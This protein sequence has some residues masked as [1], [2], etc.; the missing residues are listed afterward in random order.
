MHITCVYIMHI[1]ILTGTA[2]PTD[3]II[4]EL[5]VARNP[6][7]PL[8]SSKAGELELSNLN[9]RIFNDIQYNIEKLEC[10][11]QSFQVVAG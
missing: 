1:C 4:A 6:L 9:M 3:I 7:T 8:D 2:T 10:Y 5:A 11:D